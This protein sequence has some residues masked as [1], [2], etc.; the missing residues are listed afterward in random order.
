MSHIVSLT[1]RL[2]IVNP[3]VNTVTRMVDKAEA[4]LSPQI[5]ERRKY[6]ELHG[7]NWTDKPASI[8]ATLDSLNHLTRLTTERLAPVADGSCTR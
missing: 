4:L 3:M 7:D 6:M 1:V 5:E 2:R 8:S